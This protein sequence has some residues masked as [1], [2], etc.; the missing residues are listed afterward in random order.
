MTP[1]TK[2]N[3]SIHYYGEGKNARMDRLFEILLECYGPDTTSPGARPN[4]DIASDPTYGQCS[5][6]ALIVNDL[7]GGTIRHIGQHGA[8][9]SHYFNEI[10]GEYYDLTSNQF[11]AIGLKPEY[12]PN[13]IMS[14]D[15]CLNNP[16]TKQ[17]YEI[18]KKRVLKNTPEL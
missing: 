15:Y 3:I 13:E 12:E 11:A 14:R 6:T 1:L 4:Y 7:F 17:R 5:V 2:S 16:D 8:D 10:D 18:L 9:F